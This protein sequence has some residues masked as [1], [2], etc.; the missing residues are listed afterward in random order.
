M[1]DVYETLLY[2]AFSMSNQGQII[3]VDAVKQPLTL[4]LC[5]KGPRC[6]APTYYS[7]LSCGFQP[8]LGP[9]LS[10]QE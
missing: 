9:T 5:E 4:L 3:T 2:I 1:Q 6:Q 7:L 8:A 10:V